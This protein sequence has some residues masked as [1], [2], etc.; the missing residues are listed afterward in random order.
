MQNEMKKRARE[1]T[2]VLR[3]LAQILF[4]LCVAGAGV[5]A[6]GGIVLLFVPG[7]FLQGMPGGR[8]SIELGDMLVYRLHEGLSFQDMLPLYRVSSFVISVCFLAGVFFIHQM[9]QLLK[10]V[11]EGRPFTPDNAKR[12]TIMGLILIAFSIV[13]RIGM[14][15]ILQTTLNLAPIPEMDVTLSLDMNG[16]FVGVL[17]LVL[18]AIF[19]YGSYLQDEYDATV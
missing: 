18:A 12:L 3:I 10:A 1:A 16:I 14:F 4:W 19:R 6:A 15:L 2:R 13:Y 17:V 8:L 7:D 9:A 11:E 5:C